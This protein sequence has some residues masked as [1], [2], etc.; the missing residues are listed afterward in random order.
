MTWPF[1]RKKEQRYER[2]TALEEQARA[3]EIKLVE[4]VLELDRKRT[5]LR[6]LNLLTEA[7]LK[8]LGGTHRV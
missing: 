8:D 7:A 3:G 6:D 5:Y 4:K 1:G 2:V